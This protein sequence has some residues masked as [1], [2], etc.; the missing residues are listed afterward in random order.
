MKKITPWIW[1]A[2]LAAILIGWLFGSMFGSAQTLPTP[3]AFEN[4]VHPPPYRD[5]MPASFQQIGMLTPSNGGE[6]K[7]LPLF[8]RRLNRDR[9]QYYAI[10]NQHNDIKLPLKIGKKSALDDY[11]V[12]EQYSG[13]KVFVEGY[14]ENFDV[15]LYDSVI[16]YASP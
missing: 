14:N 7:I 16:K 1:I 2:L 11:G 3:T 12:A 4:D 8:A 15:K 9:W 13:D 5:P 10:S 6:K